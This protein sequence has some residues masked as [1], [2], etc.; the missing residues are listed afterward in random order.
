MICLGEK[1]KEEMNVMEIL[2]P[3][4]PEDK[5]MK[6]ITMAPLQVSVLPMVIIMEC[7]RS[8]PDLCS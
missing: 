7:E 8:P 1:A 4:S 5:K 3:A 2:P 6:P